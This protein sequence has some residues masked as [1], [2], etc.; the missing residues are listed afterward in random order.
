MPATNAAAP[1]FGSF[2]PPSKTGKCC[3]GKRQ[4]RDQRN[5][6]IDILQKMVRQRD[7]SA[8]DFENSGKLDLAEQERTEQAIIREFLPEQLSEDEVRSACEET[9]SRKLK[10]MVCGTSAD[11]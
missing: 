9:V 8:A 3:P 11:A 10:P 7:E 2:R 1:L 5:E 4:R 6:V